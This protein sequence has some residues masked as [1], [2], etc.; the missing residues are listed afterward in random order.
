MLS[1]MYRLKVRVRIMLNYII[2]EDSNGNDILINLDH[3]ITV[4][5]DTDGKTEMI[6]RNNKVVHLETPLANIAATIHLIQ[7]AEM[8]RGASNE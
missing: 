5:T 4:R 8:N 3:I 7:V 1:M 2:A 6:D